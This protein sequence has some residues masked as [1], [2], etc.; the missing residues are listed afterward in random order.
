MNIETAPATLARQSLTHYLTTGETLPV[1]LELPSLLQG[2]AGVFVSLKKQGQ[3][4][5]CIGTFGPTQPTIAAEIIRNAVSAGTEDPR[6]W[7]VE[8]SELADIDIS[9][10]ILS[11][12]E[13][14]GSLTE[15]D[16]RKYGVIVRQGRRSGLLLPD[17]EGVD[18]TEDQV[19]IAMQK[20]GISPGE[21]IELYRFTV[22]RYGK[23]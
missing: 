12:P 15:L 3:L 11:S 8:A 10:D 23:E 2:Q 18:T 20:A 17:L 22:T 7:P 14:I 19:G 6:F 13:R 9:V 5:G 21:E 1:P 4:R 16:P